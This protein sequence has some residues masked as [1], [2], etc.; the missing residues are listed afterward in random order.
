MM[1]FFKKYLLRKEIGSWLVF[2]CVCRF[3]I[4]F[5]VGG[6]GGVESNEGGFGIR[7]CGLNGREVGAMW[8]HIDES[9]S[10]QGVVRIGLPVDQ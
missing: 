2:G 9:G 3:D 7:H 10:C 1:G 6:V 8:G 5:L 4:F